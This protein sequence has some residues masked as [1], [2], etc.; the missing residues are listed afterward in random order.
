MNMRMKATPAENTSWPEPK[1]LE[2]KLP[3]VEAFDEGLLPDCVRPYI[4]D[5]AERM[6]VPVDYPAAGLIVILGGTI[7]RRAIIQ[8][9]ERDSEWIEVPNYG[10]IVGPP[11]TLKSP[12]IG[13]IAENVQEI[14]KHWDKE[15]RR[16]YAKFK[17]KAAEAGADESRPKR[18]VINDATFEKLQEIMSENELGIIEIRDELAGLLASFERS[19][20]E[21]QRQF[22]LTAWNGYSP[23]TIDRIGRGTIRLDHSCLALIGGIQPGRLRQYLAALNEN[24]ATN[25]GMIQRFQIIVWPDISPDYR[26]VDRLPDGDAKEQVRKIFARILKLQ[27]E[28]PF[29][30]CF[31][32]EA[33]G[34]F[35]GWLEQ[36]ETRIRRDVVDPAL[37]AHLGNY[38]GLMPTLAL[39]F[40]MAE[41]AARG[42]AGFDGLGVTALVSHANTLLAIEWCE[43]LESH[44]RRVY[45]ITSPQM[46][47]AQELAKKIAGRIR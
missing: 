4:L 45:S 8:P 21:G 35:I 5:E 33:Q 25:D 17:G 28:K 23:Y 18:L 46:N 36:L 15:F 3:P 26:Y 47:A 9:K 2:D 10:A 43:Y 24:G 27:R 6:Q 12:V 13:A 40:E 11:G 22:Y 16:E 34:L 32:S 19:G 14:E 37:N 1:P 44:A 20:H 38:R 30:L 42:S 7:G 31:S 41:R 29:R 39:I